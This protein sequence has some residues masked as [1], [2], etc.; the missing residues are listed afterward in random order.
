MSF[1][2]KPTNFISGTITYNAEDDTTEETPA[3][4]FAPIEEPSI[5]SPEATTDLVLQCRRVL[6]LN[7]HRQQEQHHALVAQLL[8]EMGRSPTGRVICVE[9][10]VVAALERA[11]EAQNR[12]ESGPME[13]TVQICRILGNICFN[14]NKGREQVMT[15][16]CL[17]HLVSIANNRRRVE[18]RRVSTD[19]T[20]YIKAG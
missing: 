20:G 11:L 19:C 1:Q 9:R 10:G 8:A 2:Y 16:R 14:C 6:L 4:A 5:L 12:M 3:A 13:T 15:S 17:Q 7:I 18:V